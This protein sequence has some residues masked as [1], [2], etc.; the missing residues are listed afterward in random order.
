MPVGPGGRETDAAI[1]HDDGGNAVPAR[2]GHFLIPGRLPVIMGVDVDEARR[3][4][5]ARGINFLAARRTHR[6]D[7]ADAIPVDCDIARKGRPAAAVDDRTAANH[8][9]MRHGSLLAV[10]PVLGAGES[11]ACRNLS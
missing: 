6:A 10:S 4:D 5:A 7:D 8:Q 9:I 1:A 3:D 2:R 11:V